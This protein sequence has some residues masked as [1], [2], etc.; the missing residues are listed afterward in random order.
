VHVPADGLTETLSR[1]AENE[2]LGAW[3]VTVRTDRPL[4]PLEGEIAK[5]LR[6]AQPNRQRLLDEDGQI[7]PGH[8]TADD[9]LRLTKKQ[10]RAFVN[11]SAHESIMGA[12]PAGSAAPSGHWAH[13]EPAPEGHSRMLG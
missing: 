9:L 11:R 13:A 12:A 7:R 5:V 4:K 8:Y 2:E 6:D 1:I 3:L 10:A